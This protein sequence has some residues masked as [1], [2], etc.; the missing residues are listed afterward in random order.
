MDARITQSIGV[1]GAQVLNSQFAANQVRATEV[2]QQAGIQARDN[3]ARASQSATKVSTNDKERSIDQEGRV[4]G[5]FA[6]QEINDGSLDGK[7][8]VQRLNRLA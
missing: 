2:A 6:D 8:P 4:E 3:K 1:V 5:A 7:A